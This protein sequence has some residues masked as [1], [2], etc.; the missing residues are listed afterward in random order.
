MLLVVP[1]AHTNMLISGSNT[2]QMQSPTL[3]LI[4]TIAVAHILTMSSSC[5]M[6][7][8]F[9]HILGRMMKCKLCGPKRAVGFGA[10]AMSLKATFTAPK[11]LLMIVLSQGIGSLNP[12][13][14]QS[15]P[16]RAS[17]CNCSR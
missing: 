7:H 6:I 5:Q 8:H 12:S 9:A 1:P 10:L 3:I 2:R 17:M 14:L 16:Q 11:I 15:T 4:L 13:L